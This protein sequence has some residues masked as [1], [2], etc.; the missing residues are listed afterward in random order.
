MADKLVTQTHE[1][2][3]LDAAMQL[4]QS[5]GYEPQAMAE[6]LP[7]VAIGVLLAMQDMSDTHGSH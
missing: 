6:L 3:P 7:E 2:F 4:S 1:R 5:L